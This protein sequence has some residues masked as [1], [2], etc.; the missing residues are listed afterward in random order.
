MQIHSTAGAYAAKNSGSL[1]TGKIYSAGTVIKRNLAQADIEKRLADQKNGIEIKE[2]IGGIEQASSTELL[3]V[4][5]IQS[6][7]D[8]DDNLQKM[9][10]LAQFAS[11]DISSDDRKRAEREFA[12]Y[13]AD[14]DRINQTENDQLSKDGVIEQINELH[15]AAQSD[16]GSAAQG[17]TSGGNNQSAGGLDSA[18]PGSFETQTEAELKANRQ[19][20]SW[21]QKLGIDGIGIDTKEAAQAAHEAL[22]G[23]DGAIPKI[24]KEIKDLTADKGEPQQEAK[25]IDRA[26]EG[27]NTVD[28]R[29]SSEYL[30][31]L[32]SRM[33]SDNTKSTLGPSPDESSGGAYGGAGAKLDTAG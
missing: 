23:K 32:R 27:D 2:K 31:L 15:D 13:S 4:S 6:L 17:E 26:Q 16:A 21:K 9:D 3:Q 30:L 22:A 19:P 5:D 29:S 11:G 20:Q 12:A 7:Y 1:L 10:K 25:L 33:K 28:A 14:V 18:A 8:V 24:K